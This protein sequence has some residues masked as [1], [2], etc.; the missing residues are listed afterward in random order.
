MIF[1]VALQFFF[2]SFAFGNLIVTQAPKEL[3][4]YEGEPARITCNWTIEK[5]TQIRVEWRRCHM[6]VTGAEMTTMSSLIWNIESALIPTQSSSNATTYIIANN[7]AMMAIDSVTENDSGLYICEIFIETPTYD[8]G[9]GNGTLL[10][11]RDY[12]RHTVTDNIFGYM[13]LLLIIPIMVTVYCC[14]HNRKKKK[15]L[16]LD[17]TYGNVTRKVPEAKKSTSVKCKS[18]NRRTVV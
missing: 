14:Y 8:H 6:S 3:H 11:V 5:E 18:G 12:V 13:I 4:L 16:H 17:H 7:T 1:Y 9:K 15:E 10:K 2:Q